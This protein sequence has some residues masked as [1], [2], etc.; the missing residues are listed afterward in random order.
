MAIV[1]SRT[2]LLITAKGKKVRKKNQNQKKGEVRLEE[3]RFPKAELEARSDRVT[4][5]KGKS[6]KR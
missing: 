2:G 6:G 1:V 3:D 4:G 5:G